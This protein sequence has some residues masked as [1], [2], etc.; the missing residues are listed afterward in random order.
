MKK[1]EAERMQRIKEKHLPNGYDVDNIRSGQVRRY[2]PTIYE[3]VVKDLTGERSDEEVLEYCRTEVQ[4]APMEAGTD[5][6]MLWSL[7]K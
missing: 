5:L 4:K 6:L 2:G 3:Y 7:Q 1:W